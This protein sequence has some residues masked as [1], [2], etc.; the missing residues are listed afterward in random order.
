M[1]SQQLGAFPI[2]FGPHAV[3]EAL[4]TIRRVARRNRRAAAAV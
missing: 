2:P 4:E 3:G 1:K